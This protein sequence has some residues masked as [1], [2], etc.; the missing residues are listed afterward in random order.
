M[1]NALAQGDVIFD[2]V[3]STVWPAPGHRRGY[4]R[5]FFDAGGSAIKVDDAS[6]CAHSNRSELAG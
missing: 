5:N 3:K 2:K 1:R 6:D 4:G